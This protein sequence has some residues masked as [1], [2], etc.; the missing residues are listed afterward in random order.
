MSQTANLSYLKATP[1]SP[2]VN[3]VTLYT[4]QINFLLKHYSGD[5][6]ILKYPSE[7]TLSNTYDCASLTQNLSVSCSKI[8]S[9][10]IMF[11]L[12]YNSTI[13]PNNI[14]LTI[15]N[16]TNIW[17]ASTVSF[18]IMTTTN[19]T[20][21]FYQEQG[22]TPVTYLAAQ[23]GAS[24]NNDNNIVLL[25]TSK[26]TVS[27]SSPFLF[28]QLSN[29]SLLSIVMQIP[30]D[31]TPI[32]GTCV[33]SFASSICSQ[34]SQTFT[35]TQFGDFS[36]PITIKFNTLTSYFTS[37]SSFTIN[38][39]YNSSLVLTNTQLTIQ[40]YC[41]TPCQ[42]CTSIAN[43]C[44]SCLPSPHTTQTVYFS[45]NSTCVNLCPDTYFLVNATMSC[46]KCNT[47]AC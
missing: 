17:Y 10:T 32:S 23:L 45:F 37:S 33:A 1:N 11:I 2:I 5:R 19:D 31:L 47:T 38:L 42:S 9:Q 35:I 30:T 27:L 29:S 39:Y 26:V 28:S 8:A 13:Y 25:S 14:L 20:T 41:S 40:P 15:S 21:Y 16:F 4:F 12:N 7:V 44:L 18:T 34:A 22:A 3:N 46:S 24:A 43:Q 36:S 6:V